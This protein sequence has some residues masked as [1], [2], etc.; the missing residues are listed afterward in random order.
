[1][2]KLIVFLTVLIGLSQ[3]GEEQSSDKGRGFK[4]IIGAGAGTESGMGLHLG[5]LK[6]S[7]ALQLGVGFL[8]GE[9][10]DLFY[11]AGLRYMK[12]LYYG[13]LNNTYAWS[14]G[15]TTGRKSESEHNRFTSFGL[16]LGLDYHF[17]LPLH[18][19]VDTGFRLIY[20]HNVIYFNNPCFHVGPTV[21]GSITYHW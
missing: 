19:Q 21:N 18:F 6:G 5:L 17:G 4:Y 7:H 10:A 2:K 16:G 12:Y 11:S 1:M 20:D 15:S 3:A 8:Y 9:D 13:R 14:G